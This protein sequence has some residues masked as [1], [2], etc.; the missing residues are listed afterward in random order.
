M[1][2]G[3]TRAPGLARRAWI[4]LP[5]LVSRWWFALGNGLTDGVHLLRWPRIA[6]LAPVVALV[7]GLVLPSLHEA[8]AF[9]TSRIVMAVLIAVGVTSVQLGAWLWLGYA[10]SFLAR[11]DGGFRL[12]SALE[13][14]LGTPSALAM[15]LFLVWLFAVGAGL[16]VLSVRID[17]R[18]RGWDERFG[19]VT[20][21]G[22]YLVAVAGVAFF[23]T[24][25]MPIL[26]RPLFV[27]RG[28]NPPATAVVP[29]QADW[30]IIVL[31]ALVAGSIRLVVEARSIHEHVIGAVDEL[32]RR[33]VPPGP[34]GFSRWPTGLRVAVTALGMTFLVAALIENVLHAAAVAVFF[35]AVLLLRKVI[36]EQGRLTTLGAVPVLFRF[37]IGVLASWVISRVALGFSTATTLGFTRF[38]SD[39][40][41]TALIAVCLSLAVFLVLMAPGPAADVEVAE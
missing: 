36:V 18:R 6:A 29:V 12:K 25:A 23:L 33:L 16:A 15:A 38:T 41:V 30:W 9:T 35:A 3:T 7:I 37:L 22:L 21:R 19:L 34:T 11:G 32:S 5:V 24:K 8:P 26:V 27:W 31:V 14:W 1:T 10:A 20:T 17:L 13:T 39:S 28:Q 2:T 4:D 40:F